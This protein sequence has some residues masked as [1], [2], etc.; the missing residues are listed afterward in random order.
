MAKYLDSLA[1][2]GVTL[3][4]TPEGKI[5][6]Y[7]PDSLSAKQMQVIKD[8]KAAIIAEIEA[9]FLQASD[10]YDS[11]C[12]A[13]ERAFESGKIDADTRDAHMLR[14]ARSFCVSLADRGPCECGETLFWRYGQ[15]DETLPLMCYS[16]FLP[17]EGVIPQMFAVRGNN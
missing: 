9:A 4:A 3:T 6:I 1:A 12:E 16:C 8:N 14:F 5:R 2:R 13:I 10:V 15:G 17:P 11:T 7:P